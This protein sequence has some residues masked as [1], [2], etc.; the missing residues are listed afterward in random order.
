MNFENCWG[1]TSKYFSIGLK[2]TYNN[3]QN[4]NAT[5]L[6]LDISEFKICIQT[7]N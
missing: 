3:K 6:I 7:R 1:R 4:T 2:E 5:I